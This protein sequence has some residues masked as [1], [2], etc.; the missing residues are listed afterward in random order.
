MSNL[1]V[2][3]PPP[4]G[5]ALDSL[6]TYTQYLG[7]RLVTLNLSSFAMSN[8]FKL[9]QYGGLHHTVRTEISRVDFGRLLVQM[10]G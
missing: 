10:L 6:Y 7:Q 9:L 1:A 5:H 3:Y 8:A 4:H 2:C